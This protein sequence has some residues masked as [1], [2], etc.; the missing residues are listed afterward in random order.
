MFKSAL[1]NAAKCILA[2]VNQSS[3]DLQRT[4]QW[5]EDRRGRWT[6]SKIIDFM[7]KGRGTAWGVKAKAYMLS[8]F[9]ERL[10]GTCNTPIKS[11]ADMRRG[12]ELEPYSI[13]AFELKYPEL[14]I[15]P[16]KF[17]L[18]PNCETAGASPDGKAVNRLTRKTVAG[19][20]TKSR[21][22]DNTYEKAFERVHEKH[23]EFWQLTS[24]M[25]ALEVDHLY[26]CHY[27]DMHKD[28]FDL[29]V[30]IVELSNDHV[31]QLYERI[32]DA[33]AILDQCFEMVGDFKGLAPHV[34]TERLIEVKNFIY[35]R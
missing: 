32:E 25:I 3:E 13:G 15:E 29:Q 19:Y 34:F 26:Y 7:S 35:A 1:D 33:D 21:R 22:D 20:E 27:T 31:L 28:P 18:F 9:M 24:E 17:I 5:F 10:R 11:T 30:Q 16:C 4:D 2:D 14:I 6:G 12:T 23:P 8:K